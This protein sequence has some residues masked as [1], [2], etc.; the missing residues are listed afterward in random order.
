MLKSSN[1]T[2]L[3][4]GTVLLRGEYGILTFPPYLHVIQTLHIFVTFHNISKQ[5][6][7]ELCQAQEKLG[8][9]KG[10]LPEVVFHLL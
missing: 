3:Y 1:T 7:A 6:G 5:A 9:A 2:Y 4:K 10:T 8:L